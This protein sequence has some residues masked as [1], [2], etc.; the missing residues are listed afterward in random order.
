MNNFAHAISRTSLTLCGTHLVRDVL[1][2]VRVD[3]GVPGLVS[4]PIRRT[5]VGNHHSVAIPAERVLEESRQ[6]RVSIVDVLGLALG[7]RVDAVAQSQEGTVD[8]RALLK[9]FASVL[10]I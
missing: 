2:P 3:Q 7:Q 10:Q 4:V 9:T 6:L 5:D 8:V 1:G